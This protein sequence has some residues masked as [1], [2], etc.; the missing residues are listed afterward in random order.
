MTTFRY[1]SPHDPATVL[2]RLR[3]ARAVVL[4]AEGQ[5]FR[6]QI[7]RTGRRDGY[8][9]IAE[10]EVRGDSGG[11]ELAG[12]I[13][14]SLVGLV[15][16]VAVL[17]FLCW[18]GWTGAPTWGFLLLVTGGFVAAGSLSRKPEDR[19]LELLATV[20]G[21]Q[22]GASPMVVNDRLLPPPQVSRP[23]HV[24]RRGLFRAHLVCLAIAAIGFFAPYN[25]EEP[26]LESA[27]L[28]SVMVVVLVGI[29][30]LGVGL[31]LEITDTWLAFRKTLG[32]VRVARASR[33]TETEVTRRPGVN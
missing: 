28:T 32:G 15:V 7:V 24:W 31:A 2:A 30:C 3:A 9:P 25:V 5:R 8:P 23:R 14:A 6:L 26:A 12:V 4:D 18:K 33:A 11:T 16:Q 20:A 21:A 13:R 10:G 19:L 27:V 29:G 22:K 17:A 1:F